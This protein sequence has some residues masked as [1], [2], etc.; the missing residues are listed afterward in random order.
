MEVKYGITQEY[1]TS[2]INDLES[3]A[4]R[5]DNTLG[6]KSEVSKSHTTSI[7]GK[8]DAWRIECVSSAMGSQF[9]FNV[10][11][12]VLGGDEKLYKLEFTTALLEA[13][14]ILPIGEK[15]IQSF[16]FI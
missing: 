13:P 14:K 6:M 3:I 16:R 12:Y 8:D 4:S 2:D 10:K 15:I 11:S 7:A 9:S 5:P 1:A